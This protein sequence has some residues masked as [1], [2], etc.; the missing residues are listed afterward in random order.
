[1]TGACELQALHGRLRRRR[2]GSTPAYDDG[3]TDSLACDEVIVAIGMSADTETFAAQSARATGTEDRGRP[4][5]AA[6]RLPRVFAAGDVVSGPSIITSAVGQGRRAAFMID[7]WLQGEELDGAAFD[8]RLPVVAKED[9]LAQAA[10]PQPPRASAR[11]GRRS[12]PRP[13]DFSELEPPLSEEEA[14]ASAASCL[15]CGVCSEC[16]RVHRGLPR[17][18]DQARHARGEARASR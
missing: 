2:A 9:V 4:T 13:R 15:D 6:D 8:D 5:H 17:R 1:M 11:A 3:V 7:R 16:Q 14:R 12:P 10:E 18:C